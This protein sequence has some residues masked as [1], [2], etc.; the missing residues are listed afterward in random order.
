MKH[1]QPAVIAA[2]ALAAS[3]SWLVT[4]P[5]HAAAP[6]TCE[7]KAV[8]IVA[9]TTV[10]TGT[11]GDDVVAMEPGGW[12]RFDA[13]GGNDTV[14]LTLPAEITTDHYGGR[15]RVGVLDAGGG[16]DTVVNLTPAGSTVTTMQ[17]VLGLGNDTFAGA[18]LGEKVYTDKEVGYF[19]DDPEA[20]DPGLVGQQTDVVTG[21]AEVWS[22]SPTGGLN[23]D[24]ITFGSRGGLAVMAGPMGQQGLLDFTAASEPRLEIRSLGRLGVPST[25]NVVVDNRAR[26]VTAG[27]DTVLAWAGEV[28]SFTLGQPRRMVV[29]GPAVGF[30][31]TDAAES[32]V[33]ADVLVG[34]VDL[35]GGDDVLSVQSWNNAFI[36]R[37]ADGGSG[38]DRLSIDTTCRTELKVRV[39]R[40]VT[41]DGRSGPLAGF[42]EV[43]ANGSSASGARTV[44][45]GTAR[46]DRLSASGSIV[47]VRAGAGRDQVTV[48]E[49]SL[50]RVHAGGGA[51]R[52]YASGDDVV[53]RG[54]GGADRLE[55]GGTADLDEAPGIRNQQ[56]A[57]G[58]AGRDV[59]L[60]TADDRE[61]DR[62]VGGPGRDRADGRKGRRDYCSAEVTRRCERP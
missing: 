20:A 23:A 31:G 13:L 16:D 41:C 14:C 38:R 54:Q 44:V 29:M 34:D 2:L 4:A 47:V 28:A 32:V 37:S 15:D 52:V 3:T 12:T 5:A 6:A 50:A 49:S 40:T 51:D 24:R 21:A 55:L 7:G 60:G 19:P 18:D 36:P 58:G 9:T 8:T 61:R 46:R 26:T 33:L 11:E 43:Y 27:P 45:V 25:G 35:G 62:L 1:S 30:V 56:V 22:T 39:D 53:V 48:D 10:T 57:L 17:V 59:L 42:R